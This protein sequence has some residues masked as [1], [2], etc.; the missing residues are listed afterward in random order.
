[1]QWVAQR[2]S[3]EGDLWTRKPKK[4][5]NFAAHYFHR[6]KS[7]E[8]Q[9]NRII[10]LLFIVDALLYGDTQWLKDETEHKKALQKAL[11]QGW[12]RLERP[13]NLVSNVVQQHLEKIG[14]LIMDQNHTEPVELNYEEA[15][16]WGV[17]DVAA[18]LVRVP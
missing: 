9:E 12:K 14:L 1:M 3:R 18:T 6:Y 2:C 11:A 13:L 4:G 17:G 16:A 5:R 10:P 15:S 8:L 7:F